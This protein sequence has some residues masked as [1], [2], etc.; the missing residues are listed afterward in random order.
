MK[1]NYLS[2]ITEDRPYP[3]PDACFL[4]DSNFARLALDPSVLDVEVP[5]DEMRKPERHCPKPRKQRADWYNLRA[6]LQH[7]KKMKSTYAA[8]I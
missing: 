1:Y 7:P 5:C 4:E 6:S 3:V 2:V 8:A